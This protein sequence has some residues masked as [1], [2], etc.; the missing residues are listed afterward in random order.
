MAKAFTLVQFTTGVDIQ[1]GA[2]TVENLFGSPN[3][4]VYF[5]FGGNDILR[6]GAGDDFLIGESG[7]DT[8][9]G[10]DG[11]DVLIYSSEA[12]DLAYFNYGTANFVGGAAQIQDPRD[13]QFL[14]DEWFDALSLAIAAN[15]TPVADISISGGNGFDTAVLDLSYRTTAVT[16]TLG[17]STFNLPGENINFD[18]VEQVWVRGSN[19][20]TGDQI[21]GGA[22]NDRLY[23][24]GGSDTLDGGGGDDFVFG[25]S[26]VDTL[27][28]GDGNDFIVSTNFFSHFQRTGNAPESYLVGLQ[29]IYAGT[30]FDADR[31]IDGGT[32]IDTAVIDF[33]FVGRGVNYGVDPT[34]LV[35]IDGLTTQIVG[36]EAI[37]AIDTV[38]ADQIR[39]GE[40]DDR[41]LNISGAAGDTFDGRGGIDTVELRRFGTGNINL[42]NNAAN[43]GDAQGDTYISIEN[44]VGSDSANVITGNGE[45]NT[46]FGR[47]G[48]DTLSGGDGN[49]ILEGGTGADQLNGGLGIDT[50]SYSTA[51]T[52]AGAVTGVTVDLLNPGSNTGDAAGDTFSEVENII[53]SR[54]GDV[55]RGNN[56]DNVIDGGLGR[57]TIEGRDGNDTF[58]AGNGNDSF[59]GGNGADTLV[60]SG[61]KSDYQITVAGAGFQLVDLRGANFD[62]TDTVTQVETFVFADQTRSAATLLN[63]P[64]ALPVLN[65]GPLAENATQGT[66]VGTLA[67]ADPDGNPVTF[68]LDAAGLALFS[69][70]GNQLILNPNANIDFEQGSTRSFQV[71][72]IDSSGASSGP[73]TVTV[74]IGNVNEAPGT[75]SFAGNPIPENSAGGTVIGTF[76]AV[77]PDGTAPGFEIVGGSS[78]F[79]I[80]GNR[81]VV[82]NGANL[83]FEAGATRT[84]QVRATDGSLT[85]GALDITV[86]LTNVDEPILG[87]PGNDPRIAGTP[88]DDI[89]NGLGGNDT[90]LGSNGA[91]RINGGLGT[92]TVFYT[93]VVTLD[94]LSPD[95]NSGQAEGDTFVSIERFQFSSGADSAFGGNLRDQFFGGRGADTLEGRGG[96]DILNGEVGNDEIDG[97]DGRDIITGGKGRDT[98]TGGDGTD[99][100][101]FENIADRGDTITDFSAAERDKI[102]ISRD[103]FNLDDDFILRDGTTLIVDDVPVARGTGPVFLFDTDTGLFSID[104]NGAAAGGRIAIVTL[105]DVESVTARDFVLFA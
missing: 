34:T 42:Q 54:R 39:G 7:A 60:L 88:D 45:S 61:N 1:F 48:A 16:F 78:L 15:P 13:R 30:G 77:D 62:G 69:I 40:F 74:Q 44:V 33:E 98:L 19:V 66:V 28:G 29:S 22:A 6:G 58:I 70:A 52:A 2:N 79:A 83:D 87:T 23:G 91:D 73:T 8:L 90:I 63:A 53:G 27:N 72:A 10:E 47:G 68:Q 3:T 95:D 71:S 102:R 104:K 21:T 11:D 5:G 64:P 9:A 32:G 94:R 75:P 35:T 84:L 24:E 99:F 43:T 76:S 65:A 12:V 59:D 51:V 55:L 37:W 20:A 49:D 38:F 80:S 50:V 105:A 89:I 17:G 96:A 92:D 46:L 93:K 81:L 14:L 97:G 86:R 36:V 4:D 100:F 101:V 67:A 56:G 85:S 82:A 31:L 25:G 57:D 103:G 18:S 26:G 41:F